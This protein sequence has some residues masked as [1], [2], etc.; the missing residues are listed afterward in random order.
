MELVRAGVMPLRVANCIAVLANAMRAYH[1]L[2]D[3]AERIE[4]LEESVGKNR[5]RRA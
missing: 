1:E 4:A 5:L 3:I 2:T